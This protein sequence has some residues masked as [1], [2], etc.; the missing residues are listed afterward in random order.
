M[1]LC[2]FMNFSSSVILINFLSLTLYFSCLF[3]VS[4]TTYDQD[5]SK[6]RALEYITFVCLHVIKAKRST[7]VFS[8]CEH[9]F[10]MQRSIEFSSSTN[11]I[12]GSNFQNS[13]FNDIAG[14]EM[15]IS[16]MSTRAKRP[17]NGVRDSGFVGLRS[18]MT[19]DEVDCERRGYKLTKTV[20]GTGAY[21]KVKLAYVMESKVERD[22]RLASDLEEKGHNMVGKVAFS[23][24]NA[25]V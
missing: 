13:A 25:G 20:L 15:K 1:S 6:E 17:L 16:A 8:V 23:Y 22:K 10:K 3:R 2:A 12:W 19:L 9:L 14:L 24:S 18:S 21:A 5:L 7:N 4:P 11:G